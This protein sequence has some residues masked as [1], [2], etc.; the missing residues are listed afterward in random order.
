MNKQN[1]DINGSPGKV[2]DPALSR[3]QFEL[4]IADRNGL[5]SFACVNNTHLIVYYFLLFQGVLIQ[6]MKFA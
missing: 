1:R 5:F 4:R 2:L 3:R 6:F